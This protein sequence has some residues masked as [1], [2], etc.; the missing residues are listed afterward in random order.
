MALSSHSIWVYP[1]SGSL[2]Y[3]I[4]PYKGEEFLVAAGSIPSSKSEICG[5]SLATRPSV[6]DT[7]ILNPNTRPCSIDTQGPVNQVGH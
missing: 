3:L 4:Y 5:S 2:P 7:R 6:P 1:M